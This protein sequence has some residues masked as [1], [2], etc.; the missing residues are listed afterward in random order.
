MALKRIV[1]EFFNAFGLEISKKRAESETRASMAGALRQLT[2]LGFH[3]RTVID[4]GAA[5]QTAELYEEYPKADI[6]LIEPLLEFD[7]SRRKICDTHRAQYLL[8]E[9]SERRGIT[10]LK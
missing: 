7:P 8:P 2:P 4:V 1:R 9:G 3:P 6:L 10:T 5:S